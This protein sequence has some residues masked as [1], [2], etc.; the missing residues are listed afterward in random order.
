MSSSKTFKFN[1]S[2]I[3]AKLKANLEKHKSEFKELVEKNNLLMFK[4][5]ENVLAQSKN[6]TE[7]PD[8]TKFEAVRKVK[9]EDHTTDYLQM[10]SILEMAVEEQ[11]TL[12]AAE[13]DCYVNDN[14]DWTKVFVS[15]KQ[16]Y[17]IGK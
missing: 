14:W 10:I 15:Y 1:K 7:Y 2:E 16:M 9:P 5:L 12:T 17:G 6:G 13:F 8:F 4:E 3:L 11:L